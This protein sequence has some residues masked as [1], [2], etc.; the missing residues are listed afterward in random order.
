[1]SIE[2]EVG[3]ENAAKAKRQ[4]TEELRLD[5]KKAPAP[6]SNEKLRRYLIFGGA[7][8]LVLVAGLF[9]YYFNRE[10]TDDAQVDGHITPVSAKVRKS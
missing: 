10:S 1:M 8:V 2:I 3:L 4:E 9:V 6:K 7:A 5:E